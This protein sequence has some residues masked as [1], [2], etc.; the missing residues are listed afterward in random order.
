MRAFKRSKVNVFALLLLIPALALGPIGCGPEAVATILAIAGAAGG[1][2][3]SVNQFQQIE[4]VRL[5]ME[6][7]RLQI[8]G[9][10]NGVKSRVEHQLDDEQYRTINSSGAVRINGVDVLVSR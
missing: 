9:I 10:Q 4:A 6:L 7:K 2:A 5:D 8:E 3:F 1:V